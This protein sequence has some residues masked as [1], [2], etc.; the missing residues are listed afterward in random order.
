MD[1]GG[2]EAVASKAGRGGKSSAKGKSQKQAEAPAKA[3]DG[4]KEV[5]SGS[6]KK[7]PRVSA[8]KKGEGSPEEATK[9]FA[10]RRQPKQ[11]M[12]KARFMAIR[13]AFDAIIRDRLPEFP[14][15]SE[16]LC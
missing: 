13:D 4:M 5:E 8:P 14:S 15:K 6:E 7:R 2:D 9:T 16:D 11:P 3:E 12:N 10:R 1:N